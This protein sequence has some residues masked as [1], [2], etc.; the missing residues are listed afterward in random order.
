MNDFK[1]ILDKCR[2]FLL[3]SNNR[4]NAE[5]SRQVRDLEIYQGDFWDDTTKKKYLR[6]NKKKLCLTLSDWSVLANAIV[7]PTSTSPWHI[8]LQ[9]GDFE[10]LQN[11][12]NSMEADNDLKAQIKKAFHRA[13]VC[14]A[15]YLVVSTALD[16]ITGEPK[17]IFEFV[18]KQSSVAIDPACEKNDASDA[19]EGAIVN[20]ISVNKAKRLYGDDVVPFNYPRS[21]PQMDFSNMSQWPDKEDMIQIV[22]YYRKNSSGTVD[23]YKICGDKVLEFIELPI[24]F[25]PII[26]FAGYEKYDQ[27]NT[28]YTGI[29]SKTYSLQLGLNIA[30]STLMERANRSIKA[31]VIA[32]TNAVKNLNEYYE[33][34]EDED[35][36]MILYNQGADIPQVIQEQFQTGDLTQII[37]NTRELIAD[38]IGIP[39]AGILGTEDRTATEIL[40][41]NNNKQS[42]V[43]IFYDNAYMANRTL[44]RIVIE[45][46]SGGMDINFSLENGPDVVT[47]K[48][49]RR[50]EL[51][52]VAQLMP[53][54]LQPIVAVK[55]C[56]TID[57]D[58]IEGMKADLVANLP[59]NMKIVS[60]QPAD[61][62]A[63][64]E[65]N[66]MQSVLEQTMNTLEM[67]QQENQQLKQQVYQLSL[68]VNNKKENIDLDLLK[69]LDDHAI[70]KAKLA[71]EQE[72]LGM[73][74]AQTA[75]DNEVKLA[76]K[77]V[78]LEEK[79]LKSKIGG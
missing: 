44:G 30:Y 56:D 29:V 36:K 35:G 68:S 58:F 51:N 49:K 60:E 4:Y 13:I 64:H 5:I 65:L 21:M 33:K 27:C 63:I 52:A 3:K 79:K 25:I 53:P 20:Y 62:V 43:A 7:S 17:V 24:R 22:S 23:Y 46:V 8:S 48:L 26:R 59:N 10:E 76:D 38:T 31:S 1:E 71:I 70:A 14:G 12:I 11:T 69:H 73:D 2:D 47:D 15:G 9:Q 37:Q 34:M 74:E 66:R 67:V 78:D 42:N 16:E 41:Q 61:P 77:L 54:D 40:I 19:E 50:Q 72:K 32:S 75:F 28:S 55:M 57:S 18:Q 6:T 39:L 45:L